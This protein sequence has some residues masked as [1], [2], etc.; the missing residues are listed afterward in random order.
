MTATA[1]PPTTA[2]ASA[3]ATATADKSAGRPEK[4]KPAASETSPKA[5]KA[6]AAEASAR[7]ADKAHTVTE[8][9]ATRP[10]RQGPRRRRCVLRQG[11]RLGRRGGGQAGRGAQTG[12]PGPV[13]LPLGDE[14]DEHHR[15]D[16]DRQGTGHRRRHRHAQAGADLRDPPRPRR[17]ERQHLL[18]GRARD[19]ARRLRL[20]ARARLQLPA[21]PRRHLR[22]AVADPQVRPAH[23]RHRL[24]RH[25]PAQGRRALLRADQ[26]RGDQLRAAGEDEGEDLLRQPDAALP[27]G[28]DQPRDR[29]GRTSPAASWTC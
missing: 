7:Q 5:E 6:S 26:G 27:A 13:D 24:R 21:R 29:A 18:R 8:D 15:A 25:P 11:S 23:R 3:A 14:G 22:V 10:A 17:E 12:R 28:E 2:E 1:A 16:Q 9:T 20:P 19:P 4:D